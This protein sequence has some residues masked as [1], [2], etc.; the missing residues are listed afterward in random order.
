MI[1]D[2]KCPAVLMKYHFQRFH[3]NKGDFSTREKQ[4]FRTCFWDLADLPGVVAVS[5]AAL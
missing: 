5:A 2:I 4:R 1:Y 3:T